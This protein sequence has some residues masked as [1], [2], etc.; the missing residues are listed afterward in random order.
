VNHP[1]HHGGNHE[2]LRRRLGLGDAPLLDFSTCLNPLGPPPDAIEAACRAIGEAGRYPEPGSPR[3]VERLAEHHDVPVDRVIVSA[4]TTE[5]LGIIGQSLREVL[6]YHAQALGDAALPLSHLVDPTYGEYRRVSKQN[7]LRAKVWGEHVLGWEQDVLPR[8][9]NG[10]FWTGHPDNPTGRAWHRATLEKFVSETLGLLT[11]VNESLLPFFPDEADR[12]MIPAAKDRE[13]LL[14]LRSMSSFYAIPGLR[15]GYAIAPPDMVTRLR[16]YQDPW[17]VPAHAEAAALAT[18]D[19]PE[20]REESIKLIAE[21]SSRLV[22]RL[23]DIPGLR[24]AWPDRIRPATAPPLPNFVLV[25]L[26]QTDWDSIRLQEAL[27]RR[28]IYVRECSDF[29]GLEVGAL[30]TGPD[31]LVATRGQIRV[32]VRKPD[33]NDRLLSEMADLLASN[34]PDRPTGPRG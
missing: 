8:E 14:V 1:I 21:E 34:P 15:I 27:A 6:A 16:Q 31:Q 2:S 32:A 3:L 28:G 30:L 25:S 33:E 26:T 10:I 7:E 20:Y 17:T 29:P 24:P 5:L 9:A 12:T 11:V 13:N 4:G 22:D 18:L 23:W 19:S